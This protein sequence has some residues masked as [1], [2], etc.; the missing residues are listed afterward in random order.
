M[1]DDDRRDHGRHQITSLM[2]IKM[3]L[4]D[5]GEPFPCRIDDVS[6]DGLGILSR[7]PLLQGQRVVFETLGA[8]Y[9]FEAAWCREAERREWRCGLRL[10]DEG[11]DLQVLFS[12]LINA[13]GSGRGG[14]SVM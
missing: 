13:N 9:T 11:V 4:A 3:M 5:T 8:R 6:S 7:R 2:P 10:C 14:R 1:H 12:G